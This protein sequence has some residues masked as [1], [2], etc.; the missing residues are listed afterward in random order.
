[1]YRSISYEECIKFIEHK[2]LI[3]L[4]EALEDNN[5]EVV[6]TRTTENNIADSDKQ[7]TI[8][9]MKVSDINNRIEID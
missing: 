5:Y 7:S 1:M 3:K 2:L 8:R 9:E 6:M 4:K